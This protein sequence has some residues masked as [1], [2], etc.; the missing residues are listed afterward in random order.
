MRFGDDNPNWLYAG[1]VLDPDIGIL[2]QVILKK[3]T[4]SAE[5]EY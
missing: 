5:E 1:A 3:L 2:R 4:Q